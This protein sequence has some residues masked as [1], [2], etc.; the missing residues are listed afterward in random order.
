MSEKALNRNI[1][2][3]YIFNVTINLIFVGPIFV[4]F[5]LDNGLSMTQ[6][7]L[8][9]TIFAGVIVALE[10]PTGY[11]ADKLGRRI[12]LI[13]SVLFISVGA[14]VYSLSH[15]FSQFMLG[16]IVWGVGSSL[17]S[18]CID[19][20]LYDTL[21]AIGR[22]GEYQKIQGRANLIMLITCGVCALVGGW[23]GAMN[24]RW[25]LYASFIGL[26]IGIPVPFLLKEPPRIKGGHRRGE[27]YYIYKIHRFALYK[28]KEVR[29]LIALG[30]LISGIGTVGYWLY[31]PYMKS[32]G[33]PIVW[34]GLIFAGFNAFAALSSG[35]AHRISGR[36]GKA[37]SLTSI[38]L[39]LGLSNTL[40]G[41][42]VHPF[43]CLLILGQQFARGF[44]PPVISDYLNRQVWA[45]KRATVNSIKNLLG[46]VTFMIVAPFVGFL[47]DRTS[48]F[49]G[50]ETVGAF[51]VIT[52][53]FYILMMKKDKVL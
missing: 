33:I 9:E 28:N 49:W 20:M 35:L 30:A 47:V 24:L 10:V 2:V 37:L 23:L 34:F 41:F 42:L 8:L 1:T 12:S 40:M 43:G 14:L 51:T 15:R 31:Q 11:F 7:M 4:L 50:L 3:L 26:T 46:R 13:L 39:S 48:L 32:A 17:L 6:I 45:D 38:P 16:E 25:S 52:G 53:L 36:I 19:A 18:G 44:G 29:W 5:L 22:E 21:S 27:L